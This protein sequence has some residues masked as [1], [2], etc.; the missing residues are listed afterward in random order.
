VATQSGWKLK[1]VDLVGDVVLKHFN[2]SEMTS[3]PTTLLL[4]DKGD[5]AIQFGAVVVIGERVGGDYNIFQTPL[6]YPQSIE[7]L[8][9]FG[10]LC[11]DLQRFAH[12]SLRETLWETEPVS[13]ERLCELARGYTLL[14]LPRGGPLVAYD[15][16][17]KVLPFHWPGEFAELVDDLRR[18]FALQQLWGLVDLSG[19]R[20]FLH[21]LEPEV[22]FSLFRAVSREGRWGV[23][24]ADEE[25][26]L[27][28][29]MASESAVGSGREFHSGQA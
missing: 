22:Q 14:H 1:I 21:V 9:P 29:A 16:D 19:E 5:F 2:L 20:R 23:E 25:P 10:V 17:W 13:P 27:G 28:F 6:E 7:S 15:G 3:K 26:I 18:R 24:R 11:R 12:I 8:G 4:A